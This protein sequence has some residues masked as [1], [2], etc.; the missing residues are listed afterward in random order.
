MSLHY[1]RSAHCPRFDAPLSN[2]YTR[3]GEIYPSGWDRWS[4]RGGT[5]A[6]PH[7]TCTAGMFTAW[8]D[9]PLLVEAS[10]RCRSTAD[11]A[12]WRTTR[13]LRTAGETLGQE[14]RCKS[15]AAC[16]NG[17]G[18]LDLSVSLSLSVLP[19]W[20]PSRP[21][22]RPAT[23]PAESHVELGHSVHR[24]PVKRGANVRVDGLLCAGN[25]AGGGKNLM[26][27]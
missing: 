25:S 20:D 1:S 2:T 16:A 6:G 9:Q 22:R 3:H 14:V 21:R 26:V 15:Y 23:C 12:L 11:Q 8:M 19:G 27:W 7:S 4:R 5:I 13:V 17:R 18:P 10:E 24:G